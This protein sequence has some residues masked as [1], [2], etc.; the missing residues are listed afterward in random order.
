MLVKCSGLRRQG[1]VYIA[2][3]SDQKV[4]NLPR[5]IVSGSKWVDYKG[6]PRGHW[7]GATNDNI[8]RKQ[9][10]QEERPKN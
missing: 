2:I 8:V 5:Y 3:G 4:P 6:V 9:S 10:N 1:T 7:R